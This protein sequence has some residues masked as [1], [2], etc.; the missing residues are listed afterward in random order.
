MAKPRSQ[1]VKVEGVFLHTLLLNHVPHFPKWGIIGFPGSRRVQR[2]LWH[3]TQLYRF[4]AILN[5]KEKRFFAT[6]PTFLVES[7]SNDLQTKPHNIWRLEF[8]F[9]QL[10]VSYSQSNW[11]CRINVTFFRYLSYKVVQSSPNLAQ[12]I[13]IP[14]LT[15]DITCFFDFLNRLTGTANQSHQPSHHKGSEVI[16]QHLFTALTPNVV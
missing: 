13:F 6:L 4:S 7:S 5:V 2:T 12:V 9:S 14:S 3:H 16:S 10:F 8:W 11:C 15:K 1:W